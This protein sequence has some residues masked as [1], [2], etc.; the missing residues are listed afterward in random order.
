M[1]K[2]IFCVGN[3]HLDPM[4]LWRWQ[5][6]SCEVKATIGSAL[7]RM[8]EYPEFKFICSSASVYEWIEEFD[9]QMFEEIKQRVAEG[10]F[11][12]VGG[13]YVQPDCNLPS[14]ESFVR[15]SLYSQRYF[16]EK[17]GKIARTGYNVDSFGHNGMLPQ[18]LK[19][20]G[21]NSYVFMRPGNHEKDLPGQLFRWESADGSQ[22]LAARLSDPYCKKSQ[23]SEEMDEHINNTI[24]HDPVNDELF[25]FYGVGNHGGGPTKKNI[26]MI[27]EA[28]KNHPD[29]EFIFSDVTDL[30]ERI[31]YKKDRLPVLKDDLQYHAIGCY[32]TLSH[33]KDA[34][35]R[36]ECSLTSAEH[37]AMLA[38]VTCN[39]PLPSNDII[40][41]AWKDVLFSHFHDSFG[42]C[43]IKTAHDDT[44]LMLSESRAVA[45]RVEN[46]ALQTLSWQV[47][48]HDAEKGIPVMFFNP[49]GFAVDTVAQ[50]VVEEGNA[51]FDEQG[52][53]V[54]CQVVRAEANLVFK[55]DMAFGVQVPALGYK[56]YYIRPVEALDEFETSL[57]V[58]DNALENADY[59]LE[60]EAHTGYMTRFYDKKREKELLSGFGAIPVVIDETGYDTWAHGKTT[61][62]REIARFADGKITVIEKGP[63]RATLKVESR[64]NDS[65]LT[66]YFTLPEKGEPQVRVVA[67]WHEKHKMLKLRFE[68]A[69]ENP[70]AYY[71]I[72]FGVK[73]RETDG[74]EYP[75]L[76]WQALRSG[77]EGLAICNDGKYS[78]SAKGSAMDIT[79]L[80]SPYYNDHCA[81]EDPEGIFTEQGLQEFKYVL[82][83]VTEKGWGKVIARARLLNTPVTS[84]IE[85]NHKGTLPTE[86]SILNIAEDNIMLSAFK[87]SEDGKGI[88]LRAYETD[89]VETTA[90]ITGSGLGAPLT[91][92]FTPYSVNTYYLE[93]GANQWKEINLIELDGI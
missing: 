22:V 9:P 62:D 79:V 81:E 61:F 16:F 78:F 91:A 12:I 73:Q 70:T 10:R 92:R 11:I 76:M 34:I 17:F 31:D 88:V 65:T 85:N 45:A 67:D 89:G 56:T 38:K 3:G 21:M 84:I 71:E 83:P 59:R 42:G 19:K 47:D 36:A 82:L 8:K 77:E 63:V 7:D 80:R 41:T 25:F 29:M 64:Y 5:E 74:K 26:E 60:F 43:S 58:E 15:Q 4:W 6:G 46:N 48:T 87:P 54:P 66:Q 37:F 1:G 20:S 32:S 86:N 14:G 51:I 39:K 55:K 75:G 93:N 57:V 50:V 23:N 24:E 68:T 53:K 72:P 49:H 2:Q 28:R 44:M 30:F 52:N 90:H 35:R 27:L 69:L 40:K 33:V 18:I 13:Q